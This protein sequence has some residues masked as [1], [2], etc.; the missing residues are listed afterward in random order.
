LKE[1]MKKRGLKSPDLAD[2]LALAFQSQPT[3]SE[4]RMPRYSH[5]AR[6]RLAG[7][8]NKEFYVRGEA[9]FT[10]TWRPGEIV[11]DAKGGRRRVFVMPIPENLVPSGHLPPKE[12]LP[13]W[14]LTNMT[15]NGWINWP[16]APAMEING[17]LVQGGWYD[18]V[19]AVGLD[20]KQS[21]V[22]IRRWT[23]PPVWRTNATTRLLPLPQQ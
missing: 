20:E 2:A 9:P 17:T 1:D 3:V 10:C 21:K 15:T 7:I 12:S 19:M 6:P 13:D 4:F 16:V 5:W 11:L 22:T 8:R 18:G 14:I 23:N